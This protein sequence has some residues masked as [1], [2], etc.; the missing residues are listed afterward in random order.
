MPRWL[1]FAAIVPDAEMVPEVPAVAQTALFEPVQ[2]TVLLS[3]NRILQI[4]TTLL[5]GN[6]LHQE[7]S[8]ESPIALDCWFR[9]T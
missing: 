3:L 5:A 8:R 4:L 2:K 6:L 1:R 7:R 9:H